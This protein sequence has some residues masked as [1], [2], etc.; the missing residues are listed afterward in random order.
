MALTAEEMKSVSE[1]AAKAAV[2]AIESKQKTEAEQKAAAEAAKAAEEARVKALVDA[3]MSKRMGEAEGQR[4]APLQATP[5]VKVGE[6]ATKGTGIEMARVVKALY[7]AKQEGKSAADVA[8]SWGYVDVSKALSSGSFSGMGSLIQEEIAS[9]FIE[10]LRTDV[11]VRR[12]GARSVPLNEKLVFNGQASAGTA[13]WLGETDEITKSNPTTNQPLTLAPKKLAALCPFPNDL[14]RALGPKAEQMVSEDLRRV[15]A[16]E[17]DQ[18]LLYGVGTTNKPLGIGHTTA[19]HSDHVYAMT[20]LGSAGVPTIGEVK[21][22][23]RK[24]LKKFRLAKLPEAGQRIVWIMSPS[25]EQAIL[26]AV[27]PGGEGGNML[28]AEYVRSGTLMGKPAFVTNQITESST[29]D[30]FAFDMSHVIIGDGMGLDVEV[31]PNGHW[32]E[33]GTAKSGIS[34]DQSVVRLIKKVDIGL[35]Y[36]KA[37]I[38]VTG[39]TWGI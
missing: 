8:K 33:S 36:N 6:K 3:E 34:T 20:A 9:D 24:A 32:T 4:S 22:E 27:G 12:A 2:L 10:L 26:Q 5:G 39:M 29:A 25:I 28:E 13:Y 23:L 1:A 35:R 31:F 21:K 18:Q 19:L 11:V 30:F 16:I 37:G 14:L 38:K 15:V 7:V 17:E